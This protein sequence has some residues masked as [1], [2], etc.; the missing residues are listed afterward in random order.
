[1]EY[2]APV[3]SSIVIGLI[4]LSLGRWL[5]RKTNKNFKSLGEWGVI[6]VMFAASL[7]VFLINKLALDE[8]GILIVL[9]STWSILTFFILCFGKTNT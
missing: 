3:I 1:M 6:V 4:L 5:E 9:I 2:L 7:N 8:W